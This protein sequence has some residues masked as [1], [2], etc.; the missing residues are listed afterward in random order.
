[1]RATIKG[2]RDVK[3]PDAIE[4]RRLRIA[5]SGCRSIKSNRRATNVS[6]NPGRERG[7]FHSVNSADIK[8]ILPGLAEVV[9]CRDHRGGTAGSSEEI[10]PSVGV[11]SNSGVLSRDAR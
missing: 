7:K 10:N 5:R 6:G 4:V 1:M 11:D 2:V 8:N 9:V 3:V